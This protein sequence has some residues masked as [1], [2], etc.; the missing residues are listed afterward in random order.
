MHLYCEGVQLQ[1]LEGRPFVAVVGSRKLTDYGRETTKTI[2]RELA[3]QGVVI[4]SGLALGIDSV[5]HQAA[6]DAHGTT[7]AVLPSTL[8]EIYPASH[9]QLAAKIVAEGG[10]LITEYGADNP[11]HSGCYV[12][13]NRIISGL[14][15]AVI[16]PE[17]AERSGSLHT[18]NFAL[19]QGRDVLVVPGS[20]F[21][22]TSRGT[23]KLLKA[24]ATPITAVDDIFELLK[25]ERRTEPVLAGASAVEQAILE[26]LVEGQTDSQ[27]LFERSN[28]PIREFNQALTTLEIAGKI[29]QSGQAWT[30]RI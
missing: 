16:I 11:V 17:A 23:N 15:L 22:T 1:D 28:L 29:T 27:T 4:V 8:D 21:S 5:A 2:V 26:A 13:R 30:L 10:A 18:A 7:I 12:A 24:G 14:S 9:R 25:L 19:E 20:I 6:L 3:G